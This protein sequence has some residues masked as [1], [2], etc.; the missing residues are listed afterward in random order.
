MPRLHV[1]PFVGGG[2]VLLLIILAASSPLA[3]ADKTDPGELFRV[4]G[5]YP[6]SIVKL[7]D[8]SLVTETGEQ[9][10]DGGR[11]WRKSRTFHPASHGEDGEGR[12]IGLI[13]MKNGELGSYYSLVDQPK[14]SFDDASLGNATN[15]WYFAWSADE[16]RSWSK[17][18]PITLPGLVNG[19]AGSIIL[20]GDGR[21]V[22]FNYSQF[23]SSRFDKRGQSMGEFH[24]VRFATETEAHYAQEEAC[25]AYYSD[26]NG[27]SWSANDGWI[28]GWRD[29]RYSDDLTE[30]TGV[31]LANGDLFMIGRTVTGRLYSAESEDRGASWWPGAKPTPLASSYSPGVVCRL[32]K[33]G[34]LAVVWSQLSREEISRGLRRSRLSSAISSDNGRSWSHF[35]NLAAISVTANRAYVPPEDSFEPIWGADGVGKLPDDYR[36]FNYPQVSVV[37]DKIFVS[38]EVIVQ[39]I[40]DD[41]SEGISRIRQRSHRLTRVFT[42]GWFYSAAVNP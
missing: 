41:P 13:R 30:P 31:E 36:I 10:F 2:H 33:T 11:T 32:P 18:V 19:L 16:G 24:G 9:S 17:S 8:G 7:A 12:P 15:R 35:K 39:Y 1:N 37:D 6:G 38:Y 29:H 14:R 5:L 22:I 28:I 4:E 25:R 21:L 40:E 34:D 23:L 42:A 26:D 3:L 20:M 27:R